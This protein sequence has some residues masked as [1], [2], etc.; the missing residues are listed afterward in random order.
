MK[1]GDNF[2]SS[3]EGKLF[4][5]ILDSG[6]IYIYISSRGSGALSNPHAPKIQVGYPSKVVFSLCTRAVEGFADRQFEMV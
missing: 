6:L 3:N 2:N 1:Y 4:Q 5:D